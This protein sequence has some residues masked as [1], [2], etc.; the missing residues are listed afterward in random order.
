MI[1]V[2]TAYS[3]VIAVTPGNATPETESAKFYRYATW[4]IHDHKAGV[5]NEIS[6]GSAIGYFGGIADGIGFEI[7]PKRT[8]KSK[9]EMLKFIRTERTKL[10]KNA[11]V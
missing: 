7:P 1:R 5:F 9:V 4:D 3:L 8:F 10:V 6:R 2:G 11:K